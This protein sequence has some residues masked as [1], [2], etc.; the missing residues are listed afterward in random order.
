MINSDNHDLWRSATGRQVQIGFASKSI[1]LPI[2]VIVP[3]R[4][5]RKGIE[6]SRKYAQIASSMKAIGLVEAPVVAE[7][8]T[9]SGQYLLLDGHVRIAILKEMGVA[10][11]DCLIAN[12]DEAYTY[13]KRVN[14]LPPVQEHRMIVKAIQRG[15]KETAI[16]D[17]LG[18]DVASI[19][20]R[21]RL[22]NGIC[23]EAADMLK[24][25][26]C[27]MKV[28]DIL[29]KMSAMR[30]IEAADLMIGQNNF[31]LLFGKALLAATSDDQLATKAKKS[32]GADL[33]GP[34]SQH[35]ARMERELATLQ[36]Q[37]RTIEESYGVDNLHLT[38]ARGYIAKLVGNTG[39]VRWLSK[40]DPD[41]LAEFQNILAIETIGGLASSI[42]DSLVTGDPDPLSAGTMG[43]AAQ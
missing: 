9:T 4:S 3:L 6:E 10:S 23:P 2:D 18:L 43:D 13:N 11:V 25:T 14:R 12:D 32:R 41:C 7:D 28:F 33:S 24:D 37:V 1:S 30:Q 15:V 38:F 8:P 22:L 17:A 20:A 5:L 16:A 40:H 34:T 19:R 35:I 27:S 29:R 21:F 39:V 31:T 26:N 36:T 42:A